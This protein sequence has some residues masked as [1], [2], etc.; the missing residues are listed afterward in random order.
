MKQKLLFFFLF[1][2]SITT[3]FAQVANQPS[4]LVICDNDNDG[5]ALFDLTVLDAQ[6]LGSQSG[7]D[8]T[9]TYHETQTEAITGANPI[10]SPYG[11]V[12]SGYQTIHI[13]VEENE[14]QNTALTTVNLIVNPVPI[15]TQTT[16]LE[17][18]D[19]DNDEIAT[20]DL[21]IN[22]NQI[23]A[24]NADWSV[25][26][27]E[28]QMDAEMQLNNILTPTSYDN[29]YSPQ[30]LYVAVTDVNTGCVGFT[31]L[32]LYVLP[33]PSGA[34]G[35]PSDLEQ[36]DYNNNVTAEFDLTINEGVIN[37]SGEPFNITYFLSEADASAN[38]G[39]LATPDNFINTTNPQ[40]IYVRVEALEG[41]FAVTNFDL[42]INSLPELNLESSYTF[43]LGD[44]LVLD[45]E[46]SE[47][48]YS[49]QW[50]TDSGPLPGET[51]PFLTVSEPGFYY[52]TVV[53]FSG[54]GMVTTM[55]NV[56]EVVCT[57]I[58]N[59]GVID[60][61]EDINGNGN[62]EDDDT[63]NDNIP[64]YLD[65]DDDGDGVD[66]LIEINI[67][68]GRNVSHIFVDTDND[69]IENFLDDDDD[70]DNVLTIDEDY[71]NNGDPTD[72][73]TNNNNIPDYLEPSVALSVTGF[74]VSEFSMFPNPTKDEVTIQI[75]NSSSVDGLIN[76]YNIQGKMILKDIKLQEQS[77]TLDISNLESG[78][79]FVELTAGN[80]KTIEKLMVD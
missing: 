72:D 56:V 26:Y 25:S 44:T 30:T 7:I 19:D 38:T 64:N 78:L 4:D 51:Q 12:V 70:G 32:T 61:D 17:L 62:L 35:I 54:C 80:S 67:V 3:M 8:Y 45:T 5:F 16:P 69:L 31:T 27:Y 47:L 41:C 75:S 50:A 23:T 59:D 65:D 63:D 60:A 11:N 58:D 34:M 37:P 10:A 77:S 49:F 71:N 39:V 18:C 76:I 48:D 40:T 73:D 2:F 20:F 15:P 55:V 22:D 21:T 46:L 13:R 74:N 53:A 6:V 28:S 9:I 43:C 52:V 24:G 66:T 42:I 79:Y 68:L 29:T 14:T 57:D 33:N 1:T 36:C